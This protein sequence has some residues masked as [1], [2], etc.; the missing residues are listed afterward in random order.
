MSL[1]EINESPLEQRPD[2]R[3]SYLLTTT[4]YGSSPGSVVVA[5]FDITGGSETDVSSTKL[6]G[7]GSVAGDVIT[8]PLVIGLVAKRLYRLEI[9]FVISGNTFEPY[10]LIQCVP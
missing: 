3:I 8:T 6:S 10:C 1:V 7:T 9:Q 2:E 4:P 5:I